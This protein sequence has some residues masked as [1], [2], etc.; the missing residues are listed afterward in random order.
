MAKEPNRFNAYIG[1]AKAAQM[2]GDK[3]KA[4]A[5]YQELVTLTAGTE[6]E[7]P[8][9]ADARAFVSSN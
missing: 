3:A 9:L 7:R 8:A 5:E 2:L 1:A 4:K 6:A